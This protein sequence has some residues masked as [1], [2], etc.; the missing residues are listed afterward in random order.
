MD[1]ETAG[2]DEVPDMFV[3]SNAREQPLYSTTE[4]AGPSSD[5]AGA[6]AHVVLGDDETESEEDRPI[7]APP[8]RATGV[9]RRAS[10]AV[11]SGTNRS[12]ITRRPGVGVVTAS[13]CVCQRPDP[14]KQHLVVPCSDGRGGCNAWVHPQ[15][16][17][18]P[19]T[20]W[21]PYILGDSA[22]FPAYVCPLCVL[23][24]AC[25]SRKQQHAFSRRTLPPPLEHPAFVVE[26]V[27][28]HRSRRAPAA[29]GNTLAEP[30][31]SSLLSASLPAVVSA[32]GAPLGLPHVA[33]HGH[34]IDATGSA[35]AV[36]GTQAASDAAA[37][38]AAGD[39]GAVAAPPPPRVTEYLIKWRNRS[40]MHCTWETL[41]SLV[42]LEEMFLNSPHYDAATG[43][44]AG[45]TQAVCAARVAGRIDRY[46][47]KLSE[48][49][50]GAS[51]GT[52]FDEDALRG[53]AMRDV[54]G[55]PH[56]DSA[57][58][59][60]AALDAEEDEDREW[61]DPEWTF[62]ERI[63]ASTARLGE[64]SFDDGDAADL[65]ARLRAAAVAD[66]SES[67][68]A[69]SLAGPADQ[70]AQ[71]LY[72]VKWRGLGYEACSWEA[73]VDVGEDDLIREFRL[74]GALP[75]DCALVQAWAREARLGDEAWVRRVEKWAGGA[76]PAAPGAKR[77]RKGAKLPDPTAAA[78]VASTAARPV[79]VARSRQRKAAPAG[80]SDEEAWGQDDDDDGDPAASPEERAEGASPA[81]FEDDEFTAQLAAARAEASRVRASEA[82]LLVGGEGLVRP[83]QCAHLLG[84]FPRLGLPAE[85]SFAK[86]GQSEAYGVPWSAGGAAA[87]AAAA[88]PEAGAS[89]TATPALFLH[90]YQLE[91]LNWLLF[92]WHRHRSSLLSDEMGL[93]A[94]VRK[95]GGGRGAGESCR[96]PQ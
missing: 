82:A 85:T 21:A 18:M 75:D 96:V 9:K 23:A 73:G 3:S 36:A 64:D 28:G 84:A 76:G 40:Y 52:S 56:A 49:A 68:P 35:A 27:L 53:S 92:N 47:R 37:T 87:A 44:G 42:Q 80:E 58:A 2:Q 69:S 71:A 4:E 29:T 6:L 83:Q 12:S 30:P 15:C 88:A 81:E 11:A 41:D 33:G 8:R 17:A 34:L 22:D 90:P 38:V 61:F 95:R 72:L 70:A 66:A 55:A 19:L 86:I 13:V 51:A 14:F 74:R 59:A 45:G 57:S 67:G 7:V 24:A 77:V 50:A 32:S 62:P 46:R 1:D 65:R 5:P 78:A 10:S 26:R 93:G 89:A 91:G 39:S 60:A 94:C 54:G 20:H 25:G 16:V 79:P 63:I 31:S 43:Q 48:T